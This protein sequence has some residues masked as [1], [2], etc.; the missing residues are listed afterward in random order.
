MRNI[1]NS[2]PEKDEDLRGAPEP[3]LR[4]TVGGAIV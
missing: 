1:S 2:P 3:K 4:L